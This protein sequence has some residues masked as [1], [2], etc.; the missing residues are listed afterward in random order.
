ML[1]SINF[2]NREC[3]LYLK[4]LK[5]LKTFNTKKHGYQNLYI[6]ID[7]LLFEVKAYRTK[8]AS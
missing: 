7:L 3:Q 1:K 8:G 4:E 5:L 6:C 2:I